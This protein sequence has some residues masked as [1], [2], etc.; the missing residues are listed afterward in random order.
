MYFVVRINFII[1]EIITLSSSALVD[2]IAG[3]KM[4]S[5]CVQCAMQDVR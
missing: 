3:Q 4:A 2:E 1:R 5:L